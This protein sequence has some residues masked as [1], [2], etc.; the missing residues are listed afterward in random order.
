[1]DLSKIK[2]KWIEIVATANAN[3]IPLPMVRDPSSGKGSVSL[4]LVFISFNLCL[5]AMIGKWSG[6]LGGVD[7]A[8]ALNLFMVCAGLYFGRRVGKTGKDVTA[9]EKDEAA[10]KTKNP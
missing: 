3:G 1:M 5:A 6:K 8:Q 7:P 9:I 4:T 10:D 2:E